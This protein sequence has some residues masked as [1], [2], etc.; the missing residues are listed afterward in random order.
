MPHSLKSA[1]EWHVNLVDGVDYP[2]KH[3]QFEVLAL[4]MKGDKHASRCDRMKAMLFLERSIK[5]IAINSTG[6][7]DDQVGIGQALQRAAVFFELIAA[8]GGEGIHLVDTSDFV[9]FEVRC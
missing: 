3:R 7:V 4:P 9:R 2:K 6:A 5:G 1:N 8:L